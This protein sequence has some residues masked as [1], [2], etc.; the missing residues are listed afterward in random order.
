MYSIWKCVL[1]RKHQDRQIK[2]GVWCKLVRMKTEKWM[3]NEN[4]NENFIRTKIFS[5]QFRLLFF[6]LIPHCL[7]GEVCP[8]L[9][10]FSYGLLMINHFSFFMLWTAV[11]F[12]KQAR[13]YDLPNVWQKEDKSPASHGE[14]QVP[15]TVKLPW[16]FRYLLSFHH[17][18]SR[19]S[20]LEQKWS[21]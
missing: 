17:C 14:G 2:Y 21:M 13:I 12:Q 9:K 4:E 18:N 3:R 19:M 20:L 11:V 15:N 5:F 6:F 8:L 1:Y 7:C 16:L 10:I